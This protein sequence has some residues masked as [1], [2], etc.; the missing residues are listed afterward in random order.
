VLGRIPG[1]AITRDLADAVADWPDDDVAREVAIQALAERDGPRAVD[2]L[3][4]ML[5]RPAESILPIIARPERA[6]YRLL[7]RSATAT[8]REALREYELRAESLAG[9]RH[10]CDGV[11]RVATGKFG[12]M[13]GNIVVE[14]N[15]FRVGQDNI[16]I[17]V[18][19]KAGA[20]WGPPAV[21]SADHRYA[22]SEFAI[23]YAR[24]ER[25]RVHVEG[26]ARKKGGGDQHSRP[27]V[28]AWQE[29]LADRDGDGITDQTERLL[30]FDPANP[31]SDG[32][33]LRDGDDRAPMG[34][35]CAKRSLV[36]S[37][38]IRYALTDTSIATVYL[39]GGPV[40]VSQGPSVV[41]ES[42][43]LHAIRA[44]GP[45]L[46]VESMRLEESRAEAVIRGDSYFER[47]IV[48]PSWDG[49]WRVTNQRARNVAPSR[50][51]TKVGP[52]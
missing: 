9:W 15:L 7:A 27:L 12:G 38:L 51:N 31:D 30:G 32:D 23:D 17:W 48:E 14:T 28:A 1:R 49:S 47:L 8:A 39:A 46:S 35:E 11:D 37:A 45:Y 13:C 4:P 22:E 21:V 41:I 43:D 2:L 25:D 52:R 40:Q 34:A 44:D 3:A 10:V 50:S 36:V 18:R 19:V 5:R 26:T 20:G 42:S 6:I 33:G 29:V 24:L 16:G